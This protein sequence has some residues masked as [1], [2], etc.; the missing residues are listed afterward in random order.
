MAYAATYAP[1]SPE[2]AAIDARQGLLLLEFGVDWCPHCQAAQSPLA[3]AL[4]DYPELS[5]L[6]V[7]D[8]P[9]RP[10]GRS[11]RVKLWPT[12]IF[13]RDGQEVE[14]LVRPTAQ[15]EIAAALARLA[16]G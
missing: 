3:S 11:Y 6:K 15:P 7:E 4:A 9:G 8:G 13:I 12:L 14:R 10:L 2:R 5:H 1:D 16:A